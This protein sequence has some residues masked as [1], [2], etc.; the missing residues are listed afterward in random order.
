MPRPN[1]P[2]SLVMILQAIFAMAA[3]IGIVVI[4]LVLRDRRGRFSLT[5]LLTLTT[6]AALTAWS[7]GKLLVF[8]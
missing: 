5:M 2:V 7:W 4:F 3:P 8:R 6:L 1:E